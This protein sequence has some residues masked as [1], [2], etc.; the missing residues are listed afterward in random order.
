L[1]KP[2]PNSACLRF[3][4]RLDKA[5]RQGAHTVE[6]RSLRERR[7]YCFVKTALSVVAVV[8]VLANFMSGNCTTRSPNEGTNPRMTHS[9][10]DQCA[11]AGA[12][13]RSDAGV[14]ATSKANR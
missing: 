9:G 12:Y 2:G 10:T 11:S 3:W 14:G 6:S 13:T 1:P 7:R 4:A 5:N 8:V